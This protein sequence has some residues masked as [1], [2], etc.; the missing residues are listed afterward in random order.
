MNQK[1]YN[2]RACL[3]FLALL[4]SLGLAG[5][6]TQSSPDPAMISSAGSGN[7]RRLQEITAE[8]EDDSFSTDFGI[9]PGDLVEVSVPDIDTQMRVER[10]S[11]RGTIDLPIAGAIDVNGMSEPQLSA[12]LT[13]AYSKY[14]KDPQVDVF[15]KSYSSR[16]AAVVGM[17]NKPGLYTVNRPNETILDLIGRAGG[18]AESGGS[19]IIFVPASR[20]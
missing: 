3:V 2:F 5:C 17:V 4:W 20:N 6:A 13:D 16:Q 10:V 15:V 14:V 12:A 7:Q 19:T 11:P 18:L 1:E 9:G 8:R